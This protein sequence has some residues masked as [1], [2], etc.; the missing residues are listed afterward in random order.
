MVASYTVLPSLC[1][2]LFTLFSLPLPSLSLLLQSG[3]CQEGAV[4]G[5]CQGLCLTLDTRSALTP[6]FPASHLSKWA[7]LGASFTR[8][9]VQTLTT[10]R[11]SPLKVRR[12]QEDVVTVRGGWSPTGKLWG[13]AACHG[14]PSR[15]QVASQDRPSDRAAVP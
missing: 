14:G 2:S 6:L 4:G 1:T 10:G 5:A 11:P 3:L 15:Y 7:H 12:R 9:G 8:A 13:A